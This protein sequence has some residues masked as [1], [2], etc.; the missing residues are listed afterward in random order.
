M[1]VGMVLRHLGLI[2]PPTALLMQSDVAAS[3]L[4]CSRCSMLGSPTHTARHRRPMALA[5]VYSSRPCSLRSRGA[6]VLRLDVQAQIPRDCLTLY[7]PS[8]F[9]EPELALMIRNASTD[10]TLIHL[11]PCQASQHLT[12]AC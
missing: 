3:Y 6:A 9:I 11:Q 10:V 7:Q 1:V 8:R 12:E 5:R 2:L 4:A